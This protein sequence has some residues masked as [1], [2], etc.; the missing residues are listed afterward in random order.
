MTFNLRS[1]LVDLMAELKRIE[2]DARRDPKFWT[3]G[4]G[5]DR[6]ISWVDDAADLVRKLDEYEREEA[7]R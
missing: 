3:N 6:L 4:R 7:L 2:R 1:G 5:K